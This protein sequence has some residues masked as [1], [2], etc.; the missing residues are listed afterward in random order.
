MNCSV[1]LISCWRSV[2]SSRY[3][4]VVL[5]QASAV[6]TRTAALLRLRLCRLGRSCSGVAEEGGDAAGDGFDDIL[7]AGIDEAA[8]DE[9]NVCAEV[10]GGQFAHAVAYPNL[11][12]GETGCPSLRFLDGI[13]KRFGGIVGCLKV[14]RVARYDDQQGI[15][16]VAP[17]CFEEQLGFVCA[18]VHARAGAD[19]DGRAP[20]RSLKAMASGRESSGAR[21]RIWYCRR[22]GRWTRR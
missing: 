4:R 5:Y 10:V 2:S 17:P 15:A 16:A 21:C 11:C 9:G 1:W 18:F 19:D 7:A 8:A 3:W 20:M 14:F 22:R 12:I 13:T 6:S